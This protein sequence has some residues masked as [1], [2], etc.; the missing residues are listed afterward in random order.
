MTKTAPFWETTALA[1]MTPSQW[2]S[3]CD[4]CA[5]CCLQKL[6]DEADNEIYYTDVACRLLD[7][8]DDCNNC[9]C[10]HYPDRTAQVE[11]CMVLTAENLPQSLRWLPDTCAYKLLAQRQPLPGWHPL[12]TGDTNSVHAAGISARGRCRSELT[13]DADALEAHVVYWVNGFGER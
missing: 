13:V 2:E 7:I 11:H 12:I 1:E 4:G 9:R 3:L 6:E 5:L 10:Q 8:S